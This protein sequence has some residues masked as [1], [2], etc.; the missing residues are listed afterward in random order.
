MKEK[1]SHTFICSH[2][3]SWE[4]SSTLQDAAELICHSFV[5]MSAHQAAV[6]V[7]LVSVR[8]GLVSLDRSH[9]L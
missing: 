7:G 8:V 9:L 5:L 4:V 2:V 3:F 1:N 6:R